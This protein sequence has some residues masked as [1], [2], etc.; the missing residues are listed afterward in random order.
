M[1]VIPHPMRSSQWLLVITGKQVKR[2]R[3][4]EEECGRDGEHAG[5][6]EGER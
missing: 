5:A 2:L 3:Y 6:P 1:A 4:A